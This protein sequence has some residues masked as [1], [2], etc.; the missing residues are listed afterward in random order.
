LFWKPRP[1]RV[2][3]IKQ[4]PLHN[5]GQS[6]QERL[7]GLAEGLLPWMIMSVMMILWA[8]REWWD[9]YHPSP[10][11][12][13]AVS[14][15]AFCLVAV[16]AYKVWRRWPRILQTRL[17]L[18]GE[19]AVAETLD[20]L[21]RHGYRIIHDL[22]ELDFNIDHIVIGPTGVYTVETK[23]RSKYEHRRD[24]HVTY[25]GQHV[26]V[27]GHAPD[28]DPVEQAQAQASHVRKLLEQITGKRFFVRPVVVFPGWY[29]EKQP[30]GA[31]VWVLNDEALLK[32]VLNDKRTF[33]KQTVAQVA[34]ALET[35]ARAHD[36]GRMGSA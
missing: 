30:E 10:P 19:R 21:K 2:S 16:T 28:R 17:A 31:P 6:Q 32:F 7:E 22:V 18:R 26:C 33:D 8:A 35:H 4:P 27:D 25:D 12:P 15:V 1:K 34:D 29:V 23:T 20:Q 14:V 5:P 11:N 9:R 36:V 24:V 3:P 13:I